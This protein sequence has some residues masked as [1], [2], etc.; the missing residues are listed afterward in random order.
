MF[1]IPA[2]RHL[3]PRILPFLNSCL[4]KFYLSNIYCDIAAVKEINRKTI[5]QQ[6][7]AW[8]IERRKRIT[9][10]S[11]YKLYTYTKNKNPNWRKK[12]SDYVNP[13]NYQ[14]PAMKYGSLTGKE[15]FTAYKTKYIFKGD[16][17]RLGLVV[18]P[19]LPWFGCSVDGFLPEM[20]KTIEIKCPKLGETM[21]ISDVLPTL[22]FLD[23]NLCL[24]LTHMYYCQVQLGM[25]IL[26]VF[27][28]YLSF[29]CKI[30]K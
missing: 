12:I 6:N 2:E 22:K 9:A 25:A 18:S 5:G 14:S 13:S 23:K 26:I 28:N 29:L 24:K 27:Y 20:K 16:L 11:A 10:S 3:Q 30:N 4:K 7:N 8:K 15:A 21:D 1:N 17:V 19:T